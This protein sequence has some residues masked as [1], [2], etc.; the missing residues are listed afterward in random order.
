MKNINKVIAFLMACLLFFTAC[1]TSNMNTAYEPQLVETTSEINTEES[2]SSVSANNDYLNEEISDC[3]YV[4]DFENLNDEELLQYVEDNMYANLVAEISD[5]GYYVEDINAVYVSKEYLE[6]LAYNSKS[7]IFFG[8]TLEEVHNI[9]GNERFVFTLGENGETVVAPFEDYD[10]TYEQ[11]I[12]NVAIG[13]GVI[14]VC[15]TISAV[16]GGTGGPAAISMIFAASAKTGTI[17]ALSSGALSGVAAGVVTG[18]ET[19]DMDEAVKAAALAGSEEFKWG[20]ISGALAGGVSEYAGLCKASRFLSLNDAATI[21]RETGYPLDVIS[22]FHSME[23]YQVFKDAGLKSFMVEGKPALIKTDIDLKQID[24]K[25]RTNLERMRQG[26]APQDPQGISYE[27][28]HV[29]QRKN[30][31]LA[32]LSQAEHDNP[33]IHGFL[34]KTEAHAAGTNWDAERQAFWKAYAAMVD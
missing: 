25:G 13:S 1:G 7:N 11:V 32:I 21:Q 18:I 15:V 16:T 17:M 31:T 2:L 5:N 28:H 22:Q 19:G 34:E 4:P 24:S 10:D 27:L 8:Y 20:A 3:E 9:Y 33:A 14:L 12:K 6:E 29:G 26:L 30:G 23:E